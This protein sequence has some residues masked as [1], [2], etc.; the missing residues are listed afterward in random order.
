MDI[1]KALKN[2]GKAVLV[3]F[4]YFIIVIGLFLA[5]YDGDSDKVLDI[6]VNIIVIGFVVVMISS[7]FFF[8]KKE[9]NLEAQY[10]PVSSLLTFFFS[11]RRK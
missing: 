11:Q 1:K 10:Q 6:A 4:I 7:F 2:V 8:E 5:I 9:I 3:S